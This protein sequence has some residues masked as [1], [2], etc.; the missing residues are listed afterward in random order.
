MS[1]SG[2]S[3]SKYSNFDI[4]ICFNFVKNNTAVVF[5]PKLRIKK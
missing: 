5:K 3:L 2:Y 1:E 4:V